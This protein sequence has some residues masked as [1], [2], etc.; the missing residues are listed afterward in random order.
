MIDNCYNCSVVPE[1]VWNGNSC[2]NYEKYCTIHDENNFLCSKIELSGAWSI[3]KK[4][5]QC[6]PI[7]NLCPE[8][9]DPPVDLTGV[10]VLFGNNL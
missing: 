6:E 1:C 5:K 8:A 10:M 9:L 2:E 3:Y 7:E 4:Y